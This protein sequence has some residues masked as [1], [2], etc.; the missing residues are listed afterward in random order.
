MLG[1]IIG[2][3]VGSVYE[4]SNIKTKDFEFMTDDSFFT[5]VTVMTIAVADALLKGGT[6]DD[7]ID[8]MKKFG[9]L[10]PNADYGSNFGNWLLS[11]DRKPYNSYGNG[12]AMRVSPCAWF[13]NSLEEAE[14]LAEL[15]A[16]VTH[17]HPEGIKG[18]KAV[19][20]AIYL[21]RT[22]DSENA[23]AKIKEYI[24]GKYGYNLSR[25]LDEIRPTY[26]FDETCQETVP[27]AIIA[28]LES[29]YRFSMGRWDGSA[30]VDAIRNA[31]SLGGDSDTLA[32]IAG[33]IAEAAYD[34]PLVMLNDTFD[35]IGDQLAQVINAWLDAGKALSSGVTASETRER[36]GDDGEDGEW[37]FSKPRAIKTRIRLTEKQFARMRFGN[38]SSSQ[39]QKWHSHFENGRLHEFRIGLGCKLYE[40]TVKK[41]KSG[42]FI[43]EIIYEGDTG[44]W[45]HSMDDKQV[46]ALFKESRI[47]YNDED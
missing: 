46:I 43:S 5:D 23:K 47:P 34:I 39:D 24:E 20:A 8:S 18:A 16:S 30:F 45:S 4:Y 27:Q 32:A 33:S 38:R 44:R 19:A 9:R 14:H 36:F 11:D 6:A 42:Y 35:I 12:A 37:D 3:I 10:Y 21:A 17:N 28:F 26:R 41:G 22:T 1:A 31:V 15:S 40:A 7:F 2:D 29:E 25:T 13:A